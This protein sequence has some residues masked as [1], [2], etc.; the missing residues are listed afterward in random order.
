MAQTSVL[1][2]G[3]LLDN[4]AP[5]GQMNSYVLGDS[6]DMYIVNCTGNVDVTVIFQVAGQPSVAQCHVTNSSSNAYSLPVPAGSTEFQLSIQGVT[7]KSDSSGHPRL[8][9]DL[10][11]NS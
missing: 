11:S 10:I 3:F 8:R 9:V 2:A 4:S 6:I 7:I 1:G 5:T